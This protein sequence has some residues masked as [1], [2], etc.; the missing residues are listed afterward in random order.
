MTLRDRLSDI[1]LNALES[2]DCLGATQAGFQHDKS[3]CHAII[4]RP[5]SF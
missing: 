1:S 3:Y 2:F 5:Q 4:R